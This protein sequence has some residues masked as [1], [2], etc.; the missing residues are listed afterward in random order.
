M[1][2]QKKR[3]AGHSPWNQSNDAHNTS[4]QPQDNTPFKKLQDIRE[5][6][7]QQA[8]KYRWDPVL[9]Q[10]HN[11]YLAMLNEMIEECAI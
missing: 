11:E 2:K 4:E 5:I 1:N 9:S 10:T 3:A 7:W 8:I 6:A